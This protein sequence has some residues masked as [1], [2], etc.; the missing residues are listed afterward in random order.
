L[1][2]IR[3]PSTGCLAE[4]IVGNDR[5]MSTESF[6]AADMVDDGVSDVMAEDEVVH[7]PPAV[8]DLADSIEHHHDSNFVADVPDWDEPDPH[9]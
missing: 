6:E 1:A 4:I 3:L 7:T 2:L 9:S 8:A 5:V